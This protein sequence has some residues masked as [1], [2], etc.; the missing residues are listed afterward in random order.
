MNKT[1][2]ENTTGFIFCY[3][4]CSSYCL[5][6]IHFIN[7]SILKE[8]RLPLPFCS[9]LRCVFAESLAPSFPLSSPPSYFFSPEKKKFSSSSMPLSNVSPDQHQIAHHKIT[10]WPRLAGTSGDDLVQP[11][12]RAGPPRAL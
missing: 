3:P 11:P 4:Q 2:D 12:C 7:H 10:A 6:S 8:S 1:T 5:T 9:H